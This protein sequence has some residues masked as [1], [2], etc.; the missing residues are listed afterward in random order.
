MPVS[1]EILSGLRLI[2]NDMVWLSGV[3]HVVVGITIAALLAGFR[4]TGR[5]A[6]VSLS[7]PLASVSIVAL[8]FENPFNGA[9]FAVLAL[10]LAGL[11]W[12]ASTER[13]RLGSGWAAV[14]GS[15]LIGFG[16]VYPHFL[17]NKPW[18]V[19]LYA[20][21]LGAIPCPTVAVVVGAALLADGFGARAWRL[22]LAFTALFYSVFGT[23]RLG[24]AIDSLLLLGG[25][26]LMAQHLQGRGRQ[27]RSLEVPVS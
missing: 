6:A 21:P 4:P 11:A 7:V 10:L 23:F 13:V 22:T 14:L 1:E 3:W 8:A 5:T 20:A 25:V 26:G 18:F 16:W 15:L 9:V 17:E 2:A 24:V 12:R 19:Y 27:S